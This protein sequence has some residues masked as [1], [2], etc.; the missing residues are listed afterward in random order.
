[1]LKFKQFLHTDMASGVF[2]IIAA[3]IAMIFQNSSLSHIYDLILHAHLSVKIDDFG[4]DKSLLHWINDGLMAI[5]F[6]YVGLE[7]KREVLEGEL[8]SV[9]KAT[10][11]IIAALGGVVA[12]A[13][14]YSVLNWHDSTLMRGWAVP[15]ATDIAFAVG[16][17]ALLGNRVPRQLK[18]L[19]LSLAIIDDLVAIVIIAVFYTENLSFVAL[20]LSSGAFVLA[21]LLNRLGVK[22]IA[23]YI[24]LGVVMWICV[25]K[26]GVHATL[27]GV[28]LSMAIPIKGRE[29]GDGMRRQTD[30]PSP[31]KNLQ[32]MLH[33]WVSLMIMPVFA[34]ANAGV[35][36]EGMSWGHLAGTLPMGIMLGLFFGKQIGVFSAIWI[37]T[38]I[39]IAQRPAGV[40]WAQIYGL[41][42]LTGIGFTMSFFIGAL[43]FHDP[44][45]N[46]EVRAGVMLASALSALIGYG[47]LYFL[48]E[49]RTKSAP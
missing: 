36:L 44:L 38:K 23:P 15:V 10:L 12:P 46:N 14:I 25:L 39:G 18:I 24:L 21:I 6:L 16:I 43:A 34:F 26:S 5:F 35:K 19:L 41:S 28:F 40:S 45:L 3:A 37:S 29:S 48:A 49:K 9:R 17:F 30:N 31:L 47:Y 4:L 22:R 27:A 32:H 2:L 1:M 20:A 8:S 33:P 42:I 13:V 7:I 11:P